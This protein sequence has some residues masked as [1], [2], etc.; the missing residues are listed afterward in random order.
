MIP[1][2]RIP[3]FPRASSDFGIGIKSTSQPL[4]FNVHFG[5]KSS[6]LSSIC[7]SSGSSSESFASRI[8]LHLEPEGGVFEYL[9]I[10]ISK[11]KLGESVLSNVSYTMLSLFF[12]AT[13]SL[14]PT[15]S[16][17]SR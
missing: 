8:L 10:F 4:S 5:R 2:G 9:I 7:N 17:H 12:A 6:S 13:S 1:T 16:V 14:G 15:A 3:D 11:K